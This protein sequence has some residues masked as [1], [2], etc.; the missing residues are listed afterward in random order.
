M[1]VHLLDLG[2]R[3]P[4]LQLL[5]AVV[6]LPLP[7]GCL[8][9]RLLAALQAAVH[10]ARVLAVEPEGYTDGDVTSVVGG[11][12]AVPAGYTDVTKTRALAV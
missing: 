3:V 10:E 11:L 1:R 5:D 2:A 7:H 12:A 6:D 9:L 8:R 4:E